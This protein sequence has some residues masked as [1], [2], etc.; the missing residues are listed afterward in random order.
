[1]NTRPDIS[2]AVHQCAKFCTNPKLLHEKA[3]KHI[4][5]YLYKTQ[6]RGYVLRPEPNGKLDA[7][8]DSDFA[9]RWHRDYA[10]LRDSVLSRTGY[11]ITYCGCPVVW[12]S[13]LQ[14]EIALS[15]TEAEYI[16]LSTLMRTLLP[17]RQLLKEIYSKTFVSATQLSLAEQSQTHTNLFDTKKTTKVKLSEIFEN[18]AGCIVLATTDGHRPRT[19]HLA[20]KW[21]HFR[22]QIKSG[23]CQIT[24]VASALNW[25]DIFT[26]PLDQKTFEHLR[27]LMMGW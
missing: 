9:G 20:V 5:R 3:V 1:M 12:S 14:T 17:L 16:A 15:T 7:Y 11:V 27:L 25:A 4:G 10:E 19:K 24:K 21:H 13:K 26:K 8:V 23:A 6:T 18:N 2:F 22:D